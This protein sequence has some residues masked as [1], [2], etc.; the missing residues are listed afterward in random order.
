MRLRFVI[1]LYI[2]IIKIQCES[3]LA[4]RTSLWPQMN[5]SAKIRLKYIQQSLKGKEAVI[6]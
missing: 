4:F 6:C 3:S 2:L 5:S 1:Q